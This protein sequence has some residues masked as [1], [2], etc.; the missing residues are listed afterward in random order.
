MQVRWGVL[1][2]LVHGGAVGR[3]FISHNKAYFIVLV[4]RPTLQDPKSY[5][6]PTGNGMAIWISRKSKGVGVT[7]N[8]DRILI[9]SQD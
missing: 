1:R 7:Q 8:G 9:Q 2:L 5:P 4:F 6:N 3:V